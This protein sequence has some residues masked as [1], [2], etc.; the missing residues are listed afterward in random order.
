MIKTRITTLF[1]PLALIACAQAASAT[2]IEVVKSPY[3]GCCTAWIEHMREAGFIVQV[4][5]VEDVTPVASELGVPDELRSCHTA[6]VGGYVI[7]GHVPAGDVKRLIEQTPDAVG[8]AVPGMPIGSPGMED[9]GRSDSY[10]V[11]LIATDGK[12]TVF[13]THGGNPEV[14]AH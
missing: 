1:A 14:H 3:C 11:V 8:L 4:T 5:D 6:R 9:G 12:H 10:Q 2:V 13:A 7:E